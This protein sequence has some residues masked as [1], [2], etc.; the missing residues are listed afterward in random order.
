MLGC[1]GSRL[2][3]GVLRPC[4]QVEDVISYSLVYIRHHVDRVAVGLRLREVTTCRGVIYPHI[5]QVLLEYIALCCLVE[6]GQVP[7]DV[8]VGLGRVSHHVALLL[9]ASQLLQRV[10]W[11][12][13]HQDDLGSRQ[14]GHQGLKYPQSVSVL[15][16]GCHPQLSG[17]MVPVLLADWQ[18]KC[19][20][21]L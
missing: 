8:R 9:A 18:S 2:P 6:R 4:R 15:L 3:L 7:A 12:A 19:S 11:K 21:L 10:P 13:G 14:R 17:D 5:L 20:V 16:F 1:L